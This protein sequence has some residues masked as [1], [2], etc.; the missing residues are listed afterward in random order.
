M[1]LTLLTDFGTADYFVAAMKGV[2]LSRDERIRLVDLSHEIPPHDIRAAAFLLRSAYREFPPATVHLAVVDPGVGSQRLPIAVRTRGHYFV[3]PDNGIFGF[4]FDAEA[5]AVARRIAA[6]ELMKLPVS[7][8]F[9]GRDL[10][11]PAAAALVTGFP[12]EEVG[13]VVTKPVRLEG[14]TCQYGPT[15]CQGQ[16]IHIDRFGNCITNF[17]RERLGAPGERIVLHAGQQTIDRVRTNYQSAAGEPF[18][19]WGSAGLLEISVN[20]GSAADLLQLT[21]GDPVRLNLRAPPARG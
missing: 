14:F 17:D 15:V 1:I 20:Q 12:F 4:L 10:F 8:T 2:I 5:G 3:G 11:A 7:D 9:H 16:I 6:P 13:E 18:L 19:I 21:P